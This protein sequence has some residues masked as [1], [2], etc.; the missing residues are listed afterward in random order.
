MTRSAQQQ[1][2]TSLVQ[3]AKSLVLIAII[4]LFI[5]TFIIEPF[6][7]P[8]GSMK[9]TL[10]DYEYVFATKYNYGYSK[11]SFLF[12]T[13]QF[14]KGRFLDTEPEPGDIIIF[15]SNHDN[16]EKRYIKRL[17][18][19]PGDKIQMVSGVLYINDKPLPREYLGNVTGENGSIYKKYAE[20]LPNGVKYNAY[21]LPEERKREYNILDNTKAFNVPEGNYFFMG[22]NR[23]ESND[24]RLEIG[25]V[26][27]ENLI[28]KAQFLLF[29]TEKLLWLPNDGVVKQIEQVYHWLASIRWHRLF[30]SIYGL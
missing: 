4:A 29:S 25:F 12:L 13:P 17:I 20:I 18:G 2:T 6:F 19:G 5:R 30:H 28:A 8:T 3:E 26:P 27:F 16:G 15:K 24:S 10:L 21:Y 1:K 9:Q 22:D 23:N 14:I 11:H 7:I